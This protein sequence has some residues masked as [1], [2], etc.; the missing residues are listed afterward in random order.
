MP[1]FSCVRGACHATLL[2][3]AVPLQPK[4]VRFAQD[5]ELV[6]LSPV[7]LSSDYS[8]WSEPIPAIARYSGQPYAT[9]GV[10]EA[11]LSAMSRGLQVVIVSGVTSMAGPRNLEE[12]DVPALQGLAAAIDD[13]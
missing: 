5:V 13:A 12:S 2:P 11:I 10:L 9:P 7:H 8:G 1:I 4:A 3:V 6:L